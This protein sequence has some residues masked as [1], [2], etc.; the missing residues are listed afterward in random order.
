MDSIPDWLSITLLVLFVLVH[1]FFS[2]CET[3]FASLNKYKY[4]AAADNGS[5]TAK[6]ILWLY[7]RF[8]STIA[9]ILIG[10][11]LVAILISTISTFLFLRLFN[12]VIPDAMVSLIAS[13]AMAIVLFLFGDTMPKLI[14]KKKPDTVAK[15]FCYPLLFLVLLFYPIGYLFRLLSDMLKKAFRAKPDPE[16]T[17]A[18]FV[19]IIDEA[20][21]SG[22]FEENESDIIQHTLEFADTSVKEVFTP[23]SRMAM[24]DAYKIDRAS[25]LDYLQTCPYSRIPVYSKDKNRILGVLVV[26]NFLNAYFKNPQ[27]S[28]LNYLQKPYY[29]RTRVHLDDL[30]DGFRENHTQIALVR[31]EEKLLGMVTMEDVLEEL[32]G[33]IKENPSARKGVQP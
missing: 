30:L 6:V 22:I 13:I 12:N 24:I 9:S 17:E 32:V 2:A 27:V 3:S 28:Y 20:E 8:D 14:A 1:G 26:K 21:E 4:K 25:L 16:M 10:N 19:S 15:A 5:H 29:V 23:I 33:S 11:N 31:N 18:D 7:D